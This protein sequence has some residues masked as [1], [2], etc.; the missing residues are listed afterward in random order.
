[1][2]GYQ[3]RYELRLRDGQ[4]MPP[5]AYPMARLCRGEAFED[6]IVNVRQADQ[7]GTRTGCIGSGGFILDRDGEPDCL[8][9]IICDATEAFEAEER[10]ESM[11]NA[12]PPRC[13][14]RAPG[15]PCDTCASMKAFSN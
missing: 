7:P 11:F 6:V 8:V 5:S 3:Q 14:D 10:F 1:M 4:A 13:A 12:N 2:K 15:G 9:L